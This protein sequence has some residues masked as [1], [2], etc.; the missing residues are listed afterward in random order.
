MDEEQ[1]R[2]QAREGRVAPELSSG[3]EPGNSSSSVFEKLILTNVG[4]TARRGGL[5]ALM[6][7]SGAGK[8]SLLDCLV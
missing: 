1:G 8:T 7:P 6:G 5:T 3:G 2:V 4:G